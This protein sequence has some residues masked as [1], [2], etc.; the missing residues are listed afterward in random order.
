MAITFV[1]HVAAMTRPLHDG[2]IRNRPT[3]LYVSIPNDLAYQVKHGMLYEI[4]M[5]LLGTTVPPLRQRL[6][7]PGA[8]D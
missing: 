1:R 2:Q 3:R 8:L 4:Q 6:S 5:N 7:G